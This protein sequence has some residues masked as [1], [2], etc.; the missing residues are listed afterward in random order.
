M[1]INKEKSY[2][3]QALRGMAIIAV[4]CIHNTPGGLAQVWLRP[5]LNFSVGLFLFLSAMLSSAE[6]W[7][8]WKRIYKVAIPYVIWTFIYVLLNNLKFPAEIPLVFIKSLLTA[9][10]AA[11]MYYIFFYC[12]FTLLIPIIDKLARSKFKYLG[13]VIAPLEIIVI[14]LIP[15]VMGIE[16]NLYL[17]VLSSISCLGW[18]TYYYLGYMV[19]NNLLQMRMST[20]NIF[21]TWCIAIGL[22]IL[23]G[24]WY[25]SMGEANC[26]TQLKLTS[27][28]A[29]SFFALLAYKFVEEQKHINLKILFK[30]GEISFG[31]YF[32]HLAVM[33]V[34][35][36]VPY[37]STIVKFPISVCVTIIVTSV[38]VYIGRK[39]LG[40]FSKYLA[41]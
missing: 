19:G 37:Y 36:H 35:S 6:K 41:L 30:L 40:N 27:I 18:F 26:G 4:V 39:V 29:G 1:V 31:I 3:I 2:K 8:P 17:N 24:Y 15:L 22:Q 12:E 23:E 33:K 32:A 20:K 7:N 13:F 16:L 11:V 5:F 21:F 25:Y 38:C 14:R 9:K 34:L 28:F 10:S